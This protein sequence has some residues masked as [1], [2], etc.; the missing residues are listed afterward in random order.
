MTR[1][2]HM[3][4]WGYNH[5]EMRRSS[6]SLRCS[7]SLLTCML[8]HTHLHTYTPTHLNTHTDIQTYGHTDM[9]TCKYYIQTYRHAVI[10][11]DI[12]EH[13]SYMHTCIHP[14]IHSYK[15]TDRQTDR[16]IFCLVCVYMDM[17]IYIHTTY[18]YHSVYI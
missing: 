7:G 10:Q 6:G 11:T 15:Q 12:L 8:T 2:N 16:H 18:I 1:T 4:F 3:Q 13:T 9:Q 5:S 14:Y 17:Y